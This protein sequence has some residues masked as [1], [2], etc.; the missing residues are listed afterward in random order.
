MAIQVKGK[1]RATQEFS[2]SDTDEN[3]KKTA[4]EIPAIIKHIGDAEIRKIIIVP[5]KIV[6]IVI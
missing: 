6:N 5:K 1:L 4:I 3:I 2:V